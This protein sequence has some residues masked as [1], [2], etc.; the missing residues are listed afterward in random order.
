MARLPNVPNLLRTP[1]HKNSEVFKLFRVF[2]ICIIII[3]FNSFGVFL[4]VF[5]VLGA[6]G[7]SRGGFLAPET[8]P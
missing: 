2:K 1:P 4:E 8:P 3:I 5:S 7:A 6:P